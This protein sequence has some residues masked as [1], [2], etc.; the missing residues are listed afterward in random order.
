MLILNTLINHNFSCN[1]F[2]DGNSVPELLGDLISELD[3]NYEMV[4]VSRY[5]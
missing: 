2:F 5:R 1:Y 3:K 4:I